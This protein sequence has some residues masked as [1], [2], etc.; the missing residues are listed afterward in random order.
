MKGELHLVRVVFTRVQR[1]AK[2]SAFSARCGD[3]RLRS[4]FQLGPRPPCFLDQSGY[5]AH[6]GFTYRAHIVLSVL[7]LSTSPCTPEATEATCSTASVAMLSRTRCRVTRAP[8]CAAVSPPTMLWRVGAS[9]TCMTRE[10][11][12]L[13]PTPQVGALTENERAPLVGPNCGSISLPGKR[14][15]LSETAIRFAAQKPILGGMRNFAQTPRSPSGPPAQSTCQ[16]V[17]QT[18]RISLGTCAYSSLR[19]NKGGV[20]NIGDTPRSTGAPDRRACRIN[21]LRCSPAEPVQGISE[22][23]GN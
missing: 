16:Y 6:S 1:G 19:A 18:R 7:C 14:S 20:P 22:D 8:R 5:P 10:S 12:S 17:K 3:G 23:V 11:V 2:F 13:N 15:S 9:S 21:V 4:Q